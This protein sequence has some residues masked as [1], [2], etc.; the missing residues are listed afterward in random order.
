MI[1]AQGLIDDRA[2]FVRIRQVDGHA[3]V[4]FAGLS[5]PAILKDGQGIDLRLVPEPAQPPPV[6][7]TMVWVELP[8]AEGRT[9]R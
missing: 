4:Y 1:L 7:M 5:D 8:V 3:L 6:E 2:P 9:R